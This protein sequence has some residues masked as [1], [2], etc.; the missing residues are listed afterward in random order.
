MRPAR[1]AGHPTYCCTSL[2]RQVPPLVGACVHV[3]L[4]VPPVGRGSTSPAHGGGA[5]ESGEDRRTLRKGTL[6]AQSAAKP[7]CKSGTPK[8][9]PTPESRRGSG[10]C[11]CAWVEPNYRPHAYQTSPTTLPY[12]EA[13]ARWTRNLGGARNLQGYVV[14]QSAACVSQ[15]TAELTA[16]RPAGPQPVVH[17][18]PS[19]ALQSRPHEG[20]LVWGCRVRT[21][22]RLVRRSVLPSKR[23]N[24][25]GC[26]RDSP[27]RSAPAV[28]YASWSTVRGRDGDGAQGST[29]RYGRRA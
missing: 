23:G 18:E 21:R 16:R 24:T 4:T 28:S 13:A 26:A 6:T 5:R 10:S 15:L 22:V 20:R 25:P 29:D 17:R 9:P 7:R 14:P 8:A 12:E 2:A 3:R 1:F 19:E 11:Q 27:P